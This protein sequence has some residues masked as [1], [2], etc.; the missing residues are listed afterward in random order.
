MGAALGVSVLLELL[1]AKLVWILAA[2]LAS[3]TVAWGQAGG[4]P[5]V[6]FEED[7]YLQAMRALSEGRLS[8][9]RALAAR[10]E[11]EQPQNAGAWLDL[12]VL[13]CGLGNAVQ[14]DRLI[15]S[16]EKQFAPPAGI[17]EV[18][19]QLQARG[20]QV[21]SPG[22][23]WRLR[24]GWGSDTNANQGTS[25]SSFSIGRGSQQVDLILLPDYAPRGDHFKTVEGRYAWARATGDGSTYVQVQAR[26]NDRESRFDQVGVDLG[27]ERDWRAGAWEGQTGASV[28]LLHLGGQ[29][30]LRQA[31]VQLAATVPVAL[32][33]GMKFG[34]EAQ[35]AQV[36][37]LASQDND[38][39]LL[40]LRGVLAYRQPGLDVSLAAGRSYDW[41]LGQR[42]GGDRQGQLLTLSAQARL[43]E[44]L[45]G[46][47]SWSRQQWV[48][49]EVYSAGLID[50][51]REQQTDVLRALLTW[52]LSERQQVLLELRHVRN[53]ENIS[54][55]EYSGRSIQLGWQWQMGR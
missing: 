43:W 55:F 45:W 30:Y 23:G 50:R 22:E 34:L 10:M 17:L 6:R 12:A 54:I 39:R 2:L 8:D 46:G 28:G 27:F 49:N 19:A 18:I 11:M 1:R 7:L 25:N 3:T 21:A 35:G 38:S 47:L 36:H 5:Q 24:L 29:P 20:C 51:A 16:I 33:N 44:P 40:G 53:A 52:P 26:L 42:L 31:S 13:Q 41:Q 4:A 37:Y 15:E 32:P 9:A 48:G 14:A